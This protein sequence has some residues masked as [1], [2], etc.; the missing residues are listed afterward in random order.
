MNRN[1]SGVVQVEATSG[2]R[3][4][5]ATTECSSPASWIAVRKNGSV[6]ILPVRC[7]DDVEIVMLPT[8]LV[9]LRAA[10]M[11]DGE[12]HGAGALGDVAEPDRRAAA[13]RTD[14]Q[15]R[16]PGTRLGRRHRRRPQR[17]A[18]VGGHEPLRGQRDVAAVAGET[19]VGRVRHHVSQWMIVSGSGRI[20]GLKSVPIV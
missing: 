2:D 18:F 19:A 16:Q 14:L 10:M 4:T 12:Q 6:S 7:V 3:P 13:V 17:V 11:I 9:L 8:G 1:A 20:A 15:H 5:T